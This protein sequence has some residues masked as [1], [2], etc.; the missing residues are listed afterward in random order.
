MQ[1]GQIYEQ[2]YAANLFREERVNQGISCTDQQVAEPQ[3]SNR[4]YSLPVPTAN[5]E[6][7]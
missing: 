2:A 7:K 5:P 4:G 3:K 1:K 6:E